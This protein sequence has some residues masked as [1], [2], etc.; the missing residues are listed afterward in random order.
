VLLLFIFSVEKWAFLNDSFIS[1]LSERL[2]LR[3]SKFLID[4]LQHPTFFRHEKTG[5][6]ERGDFI[7]INSCCMGCIFCILQRAIRNLCPCE[8]MWQLQG[9]QRSCFRFVRNSI[10]HPSMKL[11]IDDTIIIKV[12]TFSS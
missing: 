8:Q 9:C 7:V 10:G 5:L 2:W 3:K 1:V 4:S 12:D 11:I 6:T